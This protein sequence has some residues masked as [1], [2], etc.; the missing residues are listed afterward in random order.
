MGQRIEEKNDDE[1][2]KRIERP[3][4]ESSQNGVVIRGSGWLVRREIGHEGRRIMARFALLV[5][6]D[7]SVMIFSTQKKARA[8]GG[9][10]PGGGTA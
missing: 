5:G 4:K 9:K 10:R 8:A 2:I 6:A 3:A 1:K 7:D